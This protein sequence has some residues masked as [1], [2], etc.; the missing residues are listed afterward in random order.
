MGEGSLT[1]VQ[2]IPD[3]TNEFDSLNDY[4]WYGGAYMLT[5]CALQLPFG[6]LFTF[7]SVQYMLLLSVLVFEIGSAI[8]G[9]AP[10]SI[11]FIIVRA[12]AGTGDARIFAGAV[13]DSQSLGTL[14][15]LIGA[16]G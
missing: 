2:A 7:F 4:G 9:A 12:I 14:L 11:A 13:R 1:L 15:V 10:S 16:A 3:I 8:S 6:K 5:C